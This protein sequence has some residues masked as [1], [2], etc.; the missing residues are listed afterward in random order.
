MI[1]LLQRDLISPIDQSGDLL[2]KDEVKLRNKIAQLNSYHRSKGFDNQKDEAIV[3]KEIDK[4]TRNLDK[5]PVYLDPEVEEYLATRAAARGVD[6]EQLVNELL[7][8]GI[9]AAS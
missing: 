7:K 9:E 4:L 1:R 2:Y 6:V 3:V 5:L 8:K